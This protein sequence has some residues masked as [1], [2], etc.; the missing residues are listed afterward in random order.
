MSSMD[1]LGAVGA[2]VASA[3]D[4]GDDVEMGVAGSSEQRMPVLRHQIAP[5]PVA[6]KAITLTMFNLGRLIP[7]VK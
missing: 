3:L 5:T 6:V 2:G 7:E 1:G 4:S